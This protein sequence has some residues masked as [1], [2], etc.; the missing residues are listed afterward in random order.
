[1]KAVN[2]LESYKAEVVKPVY[3]RQVH[4]NYDKNIS[5]GM[6]ILTKLTSMIGVSGTAFLSVGSNSA[7]SAFAG[8]AAVAGTSINFTQQLNNI[9]V[10]ITSDFKDL[11]EGLRESVVQDE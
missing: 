9:M 3:R 5:Q 11:E 7:T 6:A 2:Q 1:M 8:N 4:A 10:A